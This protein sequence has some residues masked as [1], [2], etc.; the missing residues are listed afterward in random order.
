MRAWTTAVT[1]AEDEY[2]PSG[3]PMSP[4]TGS[5]FWMWA[6]CDLR[7]GRSVDTVA[8]CQIAMIDKTLRK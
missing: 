7:I 2:M 6:L 4:L 1:K 3:P 5:Y 8:S